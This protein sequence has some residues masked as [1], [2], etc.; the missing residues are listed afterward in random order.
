MKVSVIIPTY[1][2]EDVIGQCLESLSK[3][4]FDDFEI[5]IVDD[6][7][8]DKTVDVLSNFQFTISNLQVLKQK[9]LGAG[10]ARNLGAKNAK[11]QVLVFVDADMTFDKNFL[12]DLI[13]PIFKGETKGTFS[14]NEFV[15]NWGNIWARCYNWNQ[16]WETRR[17]HPK[18]YPKLQKV[19]RAILQSE[20]QKARGFDLGGAYTDDWSLSEKLGFKATLAQGAIFYHKNPSSLK[21][22]FRHTQWVGQRRYKLGFLGALLALSRASLPFSLIVGLLKS[23]LNKEPRFLI[24]KIIYDLGESI[25]IIK[26]NVNLHPHFRANS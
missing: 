15:S 13:K 23:L 19:F 4:K 22:I 11:G 26:Y 2:E 21:E 12:K 17:R 8:S 6:G 18:K 14:K 24:F 10:S 1:N 3:Q 7:S 20:F 5:I 9:H 25:G 16:N